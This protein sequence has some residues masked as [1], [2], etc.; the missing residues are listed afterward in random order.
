[1]RTLVGAKHFAIL[2]S[3]LSTTAKHGIDALDALIQLT[4]GNPWEPQTA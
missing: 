2:R 1:M 4:T 3:Y